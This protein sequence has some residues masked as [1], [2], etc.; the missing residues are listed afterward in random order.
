[1]APFDTEAEVF[2]WT[3]NQKL[4]VGELSRHIRCEVVEWGIEI[5]DYSA[6]QIW[7]LVGVGPR[8]GFQHNI[9]RLTW[10]NHRVRVSELRSEVERSDIG[11]TSKGRDK[12]GNR[13]KVEGDA[14]EGNEATDV[15]EG[16]ALT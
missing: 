12:Q 13:G 10:F 6:K 1:M 3:V 11:T 9:E 16:R 4:A 8:M 5:L 2:Q 15:A 14:K 7:D